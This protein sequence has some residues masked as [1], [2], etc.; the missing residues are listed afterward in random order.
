MSNTSA[1]RRA[2]VRLPGQWLGPVTY[3]LGP[4]DCMGQDPRRAICSLGKHRELKG[5]DEKGSVCHNLKGI[6]GVLESATGLPSA[7]R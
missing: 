6:G 1:I 4:T 2:G 7:G 3:T 5:I